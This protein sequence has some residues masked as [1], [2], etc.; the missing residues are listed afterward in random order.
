MKLPS[1][2]RKMS[3][4]ERREAL[5]SLLKTQAL[6]DGFLDDSKYL[7]L[8]D[9]LVE[10]AAVMLAVPTGYVPEII[11][12][13]KSYVI[14]MATE[15]PSVIAAANYGSVL[16]GKSGGFTA[17]SD[18][19]VMVEQI[20]VENGD[21]VLFEKI[22]ENV[23]GINVLAE[24]SL[25]SM[26]KRGGGFKKTE[27]SFLENISIIKVELFADVC[28]AMGANLLNNLGEKIGLYLTANLNCSVLMAII[29][30]TAENRISTA[31]FS[32]PVSVLSRNGHSGIKNAERIVLACKTADTDPNRAVTHN[33]GIL[34]GITALTLAAGNDTRAVESGAHFHAAVSGRYKPLTSY[35]IEGDLLC[36]KIE[37]GLALA[38]KGGI[39][40]T[41]PMV[42]QNLKILGISSSSELSGVA[43]SL[44]L[45]QNFAALFALVTEGIQKGHMKLHNK[46]GSI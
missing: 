17:A 15:E 43:A 11:V 37:I 13:N 9:V 38:V 44:G 5:S 42:K 18:D 29:S 39:T 27:I 36:G 45:A 46:K 19:S 30:N 41:H 16:I 2:F 40:E 6:D 3:I 10:N 12:N 35:K 32:I 24:E 23:N 8:A 33:K 31:E 1:R 22:R 21:A 4:K 25:L 20:F 26:K 28:D 34:N 14:P 7:D